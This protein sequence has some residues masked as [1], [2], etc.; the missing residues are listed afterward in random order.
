[1]TEPRVSI[2]LA[3][4]NS[5]DVWESTKLE[6]QVQAM[7]SEKR[8]MFCYTLGWK[9]DE[10]G[11]LDTSEDV[12]A[13]WPR[14]PVQE[15]LPYLLYENRVLASSVLFRATE[16]RFDSSLSYSGDWVSLLRIARTG[17]AICIGERLTFWRM[18]SRNS[19]V[20]SERQ[21][22]EEVRVRSSIYSNRA[23][24]FVHG[25]PATD[26]RQGLAQNSRNLAALE[27]L[28][29]NRGAAVKA[30]IQAILLGSDRHLGLRRLGVC[31]LLGKGR[32]LLWPGDRTQF[33]NSNPVMSSLNFD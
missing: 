2:Y 8:A 12:H 7:E 6:K 16:A 24:W 17:P 1:M 19:Y 11:K 20:R 26:I 30:A 21:V 22:H 29:G 23:N 33:S 28:R 13:N 18:H 4:L 15:L 14:E 25:L 32:T 5:D 10:H 3:V 9:V 27:V 31:L